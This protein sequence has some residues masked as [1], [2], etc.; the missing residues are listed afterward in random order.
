[1]KALAAVILFL[2]LS[3]Q[4]FSLDDWHGIEPVHG[5]HGGGALTLFTMAAVAGTA[6]LLSSQVEGKEWT[7]PAAMLSI[8]IAGGIV[9]GALASQ[10]K[11]GR[12]PTAP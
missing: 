10:D 4:P 11:R 6:L 3:L 2:S 5:R 1:M 12:A 9:I 8:G 7:K